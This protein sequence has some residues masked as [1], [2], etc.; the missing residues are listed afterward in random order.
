L[1]FDD[2]PHPEHTPRLLDILKTE[3][4]AATFFVVGREAGNHPE[5]VRRIVDEG[6]TLGHH[7]FTHGDPSRMCSRELLEEVRE[8]QSVLT[9]IAGVSS[10]LFRPPHG[11]LT[12]AKLWRLWGSGQT[13]VLWNVDPKDYACRDANDLR[14]WFQQH[15]L[16]GGDVLLLH[17]NQPHAIDMLPDLIRDVRRRGLAF[18]TPREWV[19]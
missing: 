13:I 8:T 12:A 2:G 15:P 3:G 4:V 6:H 16:D 5:I 7:T 17:D 18:T 14:I 9:R 11:K 19:A 10:S 1:T